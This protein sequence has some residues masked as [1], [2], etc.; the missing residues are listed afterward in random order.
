MIP[1][2]VSNYIDKDQYRHLYFF[3]GID[4]QEKNIYNC[5]D[6]SLF[7]NQYNYI[8]NIDGSIDY[9]FFDKN[10]IKITCK[11][12]KQD[13]TFDIVILNYGR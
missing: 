5:I 2:F 1:G 13:N 7:N 11:L 9:K 4:D 6:L 8:K 12:V 10:I 3:S